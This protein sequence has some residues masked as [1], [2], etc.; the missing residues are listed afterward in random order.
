MAGLITL[1]EFA[2]KHGIKKPTVNARLKRLEKINQDK[3]L[4]I[5]TDNVIYLTEC[6]LA[7]LEKSFKDT[8]VKPPAKRKA[9]RRANT[10]PVKDNERE[11]IKVYQ[12]QIKRLE[13]DLSASRRDNERLLLQIDKLMAMIADLTGAVS[14]ALKDSQRLISQEQT[15]TLMDKTDN[16]GGQEKPREKK[17]LLARLAVA[18]RVL[19]GN[20][21]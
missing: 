5:K 14:L 8:P 6:G 20:Y 12:E 21:D 19:I 17:S 3:T 2:E 11:L 16:A 9:K 10:E 7:L 15:L 13:S 4:T 1:R 18:G